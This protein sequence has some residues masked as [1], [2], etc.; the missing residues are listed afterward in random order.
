ME[1]T[2]FISFLAIGLLLSNLLLVGYIMVNKSRSPHAHENREQGPP[3]H[4]GPRNLI[5]E[6]LHFNDAQVTEYDKLIIWHRGEIEKAD[7]RIMELKNQLY[8]T[9]GN[10]ADNVKDSLIA[11][12]AAK[13]Q[14]IER[15]HYKHFEDIKQLCTP[16][17]QADFEELTK[18]IASLFGPHKPPHKRP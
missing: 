18:E 3:R 17:Q 10:P 4:H 9:L 15:I 1:K 13:Q 6:R 14:D 5:I 11:A 8:S 12:I 2:K 16:E 7:D